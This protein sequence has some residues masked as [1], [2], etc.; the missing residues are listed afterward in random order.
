MA[1]TAKGEREVTGRQRLVYGFIGGVLPNLMKVGTALISGAVFPTWGY[2]IGVAIYGGIG[3]VVAQVYPAAKNS[4]W[5]ALAAGVLAPALIAALVS[6]T[7][8]EG[9]PPPV[10]V[11]TFQTEPST[12]TS[13]PTVWGDLLWALGKDR[14]PGTV[15]NR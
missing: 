6:G 7:T 5:S 4:L 1:A 13:Q 12:K 15:G 9:N 8:T 3:G 2:L 14:R 11:S 10:P